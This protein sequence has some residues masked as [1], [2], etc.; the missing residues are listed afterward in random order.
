MNVLHIP[1]RCDVLCAYQSKTSL[2]FFSFDPVTGVS[3]DAN[4]KA[5]CELAQISE[6]DLLVTEWSNSQYRPCHYIALDRNNKRVMLV[7][8]YD[9]PV[10]CTV[11]SD[12]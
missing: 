4:R 11:Q 3:E 1:Q 12:I 9:S 7:V 10:V 2:L 6:E 8:R 5:L